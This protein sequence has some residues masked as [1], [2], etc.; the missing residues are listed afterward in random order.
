MSEPAWAAL[1]TRTGFRPDARFN[2]PD[3]PAAPR[4]LSDAL[5]RARAEGYSAGF[6]EAEAIADARIAAALAA[7]ERIELA[8]ARL[9]ADQE[10][11]L[12]MRLHGVIEALCHSVLAAGATGSAPLAGRIA[13]ASAMLA[14]ADDDR[15]LRL[16]P[17]DLAL[18]DGALPPDL[19]VVP[20]PGLTPGSLRIETSQGGVEDGPEQWRLQLSEAL[21][22]C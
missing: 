20:D 15:V 1:S 11:T 3:V 22:L 9:A 6:A 14:R 21:A 12:R 19:P 4:S 16:H 7:R 10:E 8:F 13:R 5:E 18:L 2:G 17:D